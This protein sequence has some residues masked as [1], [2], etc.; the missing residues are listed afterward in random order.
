[1]NTE[2]DSGHACQYTCM[3]E[4]KE[5]TCDNQGGDGGL[6]GGGDELKGLWMS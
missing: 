1:M 4:A 2:C 5:R 3:S 6:G